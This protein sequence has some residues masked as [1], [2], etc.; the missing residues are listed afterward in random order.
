M[1]KRGG[2]MGGSF[3]KMSSYSK[4][5]LYCRMFETYP[6]WRLAFTH[7]GGHLPIEVQIE[8]SRSIINICICLIM[9]F[10]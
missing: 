1:L 2:V 10:F 9:F 7:I 4:V 3:E 6:S 8:N 5:K